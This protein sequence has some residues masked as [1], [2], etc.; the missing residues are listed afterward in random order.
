MILKNHKATIKEP[1]RNFILFSLEDDF[2][3][4]LIPVFDV[5][6][7]VYEAVHG[8]TQGEAI[9]DACYHCLT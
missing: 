5:E 4:P 7:Q 2:R 8:L 1:I 6:E 9:K 3:P